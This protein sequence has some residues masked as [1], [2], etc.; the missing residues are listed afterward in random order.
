MFIKPEIAETK[1]IWEIGISFT[2]DFPSSLEINTIDFDSFFD[3]ANGID[4]VTELS[5]NISFSLILDFLEISSLSSSVR[6]F[7][8]ICLTS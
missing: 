8:Q 1:G 3:G 2:D 6:V 5:T 7:F 4:G